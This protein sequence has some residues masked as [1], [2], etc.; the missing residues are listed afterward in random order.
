MGFIAPQS[1]QV[2]TSTCALNSRDHL[3]FRLTAV[4]LELFHA[5]LRRVWRHLWNDVLLHES[6]VVSLRLPDLDYVPTA[7]GWAGDVRNEAR[8][9]AGQRRKLCVH[10]V[11]LR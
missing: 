11:V 1:V 3:V 7:L 5:R 9:R 10:G 4:H 6:F 8:H 2:R